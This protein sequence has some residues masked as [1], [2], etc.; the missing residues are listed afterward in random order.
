MIQVVYPRPG[1]EVFEDRTFVLGQASPDSGLSLNGEPVAVS[2]GGYFCVPVAL[3]PGENLLRLQTG[4]ERLEVA[5]RRVPPVPLAEPGAPLACEATLILPACDMSLQPGDWL[6]VAVFANPDASVSAV[7]SGLPMAPVSLEPG[8]PDGW[9]DQRE[10]IFACLHQVRAPLPAAGWFRGWLQIPPDFCIE[11]VTLPVTF[12]LRRG[13]DLLSVDAPGRVT[14]AQRPCLLKTLKDKA[15]LR[16]FPHSGARLTPQPA[17]VTLVS[18]GLVGEWA[19]LR[20]GMNRTAYIAVP[21]VAWLPGE[22]AAPGVLELIRTRSEGPHAAWLDLVTRH[23]GPVEVLSDPTQPRRLVL[24]LHQ[25]LSRCDFVYYDPRDGVIAAVHWMPQDA[26]TVDVAVDVAG[27]LCGYDL[28]PVPE[29]YRLRLRTLPAEPDQVKILL[30]PGHGGEEPGALG[31]DGL[32]EKD[33][34][35][36]VALALRQAL[37]GAGFQ[38]ALTRWGDDTVS[39]SQREAAV[40]EW[41]THIV[42]SLHHNALPDGRDPAEHQGAS[43]YYYHAFAMPLARALQTALVQAGCPDYG[44]LYDSLHMTRIH[45]ALAVLLEIGFFTHPQEYGRL[46]DPGFQARVAEH[47]AQALREYCRG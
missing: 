7:I 19:R 20:L 12:T 25:T 39:L 43:S 5:V 21:D 4:N 3:Q 8:P 1:Q 6:E 36:T 16:T 46:L 27:R 30:D 45:Q 24:R 9:V 32:P 26:E 41:G 34:N 13:D 11:A 42:L 22:Y 38:V 23:H 2:T 33:L 37:Q 47:L 17:G 35:L 18:D 14:V 31:P 44:L 29:G 10:G 40:A 15:I 28:A